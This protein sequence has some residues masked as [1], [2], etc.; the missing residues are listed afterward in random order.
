MQQVNIK[1]DAGLKKRVD[2][3]S[4]NI[5]LSTTDAIRIF[6]KRYAAVGG[7]P[8][9]V[10][11]VC[12]REPDFNDETKRAMKEAGGGIE[13]AMVESPDELWRAIDADDES[14]RQ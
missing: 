1:V 4:E 13:I 11:Q 6:M 8:F 7:F 9:A 5:G 2:T 14:Y 12:P 3:V 10:E